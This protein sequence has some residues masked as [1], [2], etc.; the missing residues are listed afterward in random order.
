MLE[1]IL[2]ME[3]RASNKS[4]YMYIKST[5]DYFYGTR[6]FAITP[7]YAKTKSQLIQQ[8]VKIKKAIQDSKRKTIVIVCADIDREE[9]LNSN[10]AAYC[11]NKAYELVWMNLDIEDVYWGKQVNKGQ[12][13]S[14]AIKF[15]KH[16]K[17]IIS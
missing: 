3:T 16:K 11:K 1:L 17:R 2:I 10:I 12:K 13:A 14:E 5:L 15:Q 4:D 9:E 6:T 7:I 8:D